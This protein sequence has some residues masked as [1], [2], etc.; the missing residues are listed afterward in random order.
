M[1]PVAVAGTERRRDIWLAVAVCCT[2]VMLASLVML[3]T[4]T[5]YNG[6]GMRWLLLVVVVAG[7]MGFPSYWKPYLD[8]K[9]K[10]DRLRNPEEVSDGDMLPEQMMGDPRIVQMAHGNHEIMRLLQVVAQYSENLMPRTESFTFDKEENL[11]S[12]EF[13]SVVPGY[14]ASESVQ[15]GLHAKLTTAMGQGWSVDFDAAE[16]TL[17]GTRKSDVPSLAVPEMWPVVGSKEEAAR[18]F[19]NIAITVGL[20]ASGPIKFPPKQFP[21]REL[22]GSTG[23]GKSVAARAEIM[24][25]LAFGYRIFAVDGKGTDYAPF[26]RTPNFV[27]ISTSI[28]EH[29]LVIHMVF[30]ILQ[31]RRNKGS[32]LGKQG[33]NSWRETMTP[34]LLVLDE[35]AS[36]RSQMKSMLSAKELALVDNEMV[37]I[38][39]VGR[40]FRV[41]VLL[42]TQDMKADTVPSDWQD[43]FIAVASAGRP[44]PMTVRKAFP[45]EIQ[46]KVSRIGGTI[47]R[48]TPG[49]SLISVV[50][51]D[52]GAVS[53]ELYQAFWSYSPAETITEKLPP[54]VRENWTQFKDQVADRVPKM[55]PRQW[56]RTRTCGTP[57]GWIC[58]R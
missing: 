27:A 2:A 21:H 38:L 23:G 39:K 33:D 48:K 52:S 22:T 43:M 29:I 13:Y 5:A 46:G 55:Y 45:E 20:G 18:N 1:D 53:A 4:A 54:M 47:S 11:E 19:D 8:A 51:E 41:N 25:Y 56:T 26:F 37:N 32:R 12:Y 6:A 14:L 57:A 49:R 17:T 34:I 3:A 9:K 36:V 42:A 24:Q 16:D 30:E 10:A 58:R 15:N 44:A 35:W 50:D 40:E 28:H 7:V 31:S